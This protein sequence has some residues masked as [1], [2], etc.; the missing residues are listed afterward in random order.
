[1]KLLLPLVAAALFFAGCA[2][3]PATPPPAAPAVSH[4]AVPPTDDGL[5]GTG[6]V[7]RQY[8][9]FRKLWLE[10]RTL[11]ATQVQQ[12]QHALV[13]L[14]DSIT[15]GWGDK[16]APAFPGVKVANRGISGDTT[17]GVLIRL[18]EDVISLNPSGV[19]L[20]IG[21]NDLEEQAS[22][23]T[24]VTN[25]RL[26]ID[27]L[28]AHNPTMPVV[29][30]QVM[31]SAAA[32]KRPQFKIRNVNLLLREAMRDEPQVTMLDTWTLFADAQGNAI[33]AEFPDLLHPNAA[34]YAKWAAALHTA[35]ATLGFVDTE[36]DTFTPEPGFVSLFNGHDLTGWG[37]RPTTDADMRG[38]LQWQTGSADSADWPVVKEAATFDGKTSSPDGRLLAKNGR[39]VVTAPPEYRRIQKFW[40]TQ[41]FP[42]NFVLKLEFRAAPN[43]DS[44][45]YI[46]DPQLQCRD[47]GIAGPY[48]ELKNYRP[49]EWN[50]IT[51][52][53]K[54][55]F[56]HCTCNGE[57]LEDALPVPADGPIGV[58][59]DRGQMEYR[60]IRIQELP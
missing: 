12:D 45:I 3:Q 49:Q 7:R 48:K 40:T 17:R 58:E 59:G 9:W 36:P 54:D 43:A 32:K 50:E 1:M 57:L 55:G 30:C 4:F 14:G 42:K 60:R 25:V 15:Q 46:R 44:G 5:P 56:A 21:T 20:L 8:D 35:L 53:V 39:L 6:P 31:P 19:V 37:V 28:K 38:A 51:I 41:T 29:L 10:K 23:W 22:P 26:I 16:L 11:W 27:A 47:Y 52:T 33:P 34:G 24:I 2:T 18:Q 13:F